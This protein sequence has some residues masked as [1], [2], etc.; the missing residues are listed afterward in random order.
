MSRT[1]ANYTPSFDP[2][3]LLSHAG[4]PIL[5]DLG[6]IVPAISP[7]TTFV[8][9]ANYNLKDSQY[10]YLRSGTP[11]WRTFET[12]MTR[13]EGG[14]DSRLFASG[15]AAASS[16]F[17]GLLP[18]DHIVIPHVMYHGLRD[19]LRDFTE[20]WRL[21]ISEYK[22]GDI[23]SLRST[24]AAR[25][26]ALVWVETPA[27]PSMEITDIAAAVD[28]AHGAGAMC[29]ADSTLSTPLV[30]RPIDF[31][32]DFVMHSATKYLNGHSD[33]LG[34][35]VTCARDSDW[36][37]A[38][39]EHR[40]GG[41]AVAGTFEAW[42]L[43]RGMR[44]LDVRLARAMENAAA[45]AD[46]LQHDDAVEAVLYPGLPSHPGHD[47]ACAQMRGGFGAMLSILVRGDADAARRVA[48]ATRVF[49]PATSLGGVE[50]LIEHR[51]SVERPDSPVPKNLLRLSIGIESA[52]DLIDD[53]TQA[54]RQSVR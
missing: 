41:G 9:D 38:I 10:S 6:S 4:D 16:V 8:R 27:N 36:W 31:G 32:V 12:L 54:L 24:V 51:A 25:P 33:V 46:H 40:T 18:G 2:A 14:F 39:V 44:T 47:V 23:G 20:R 52:S 45:L 5:D 28:V 1:P 50:S 35:I 42:L 22:A 21:T 26:T 19:W 37:N 48:G 3:T 17:Q 49:M 53:L 30:T 11:N 7:A 13:L 15:M 29:A 43:V 34:G